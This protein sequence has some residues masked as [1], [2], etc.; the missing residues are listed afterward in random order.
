L[1]FTT[2][3]TVIT[4]ALTFL[5]GFG[6]ALIVQRGFKGVAFLRSAYFMPVVIGY[7]VAS[8]IWVWLFNDSVG[9]VNPFLTWLGVMPRPIQ[10]LSDPDTALLALVVTTVWKVTGFAMLILLVGLQA[11][12]EELYEAGRVDG[13]N[14]FQALIHITLP[15]MRST[16]ALVFVFLV[17]QFYLGFDQFFIMTQGGPRNSTITVVY[18]IFT[19]AFIGLRLGY[20]AA[21][22]LVLLVLLVVINGVQFLAIRKDPSQ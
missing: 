10:W 11:V 22:A 4:T 1:W 6:L 20:G 9:F 2:R 3:F 13:T 21:L 17:T 16:F 7:A 12:P 15:M 19:N 18:W 5:L 8:Y 14:R